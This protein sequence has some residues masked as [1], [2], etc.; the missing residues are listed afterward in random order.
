[1]MLL[2]S[3]LVSKVSKSVAGILEQVQTLV[4]ELGLFTEIK[5][6]NLTGNRLQQCGDAAGDRVVISAKQP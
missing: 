4:V 2:E 1:M 3:L 6:M 5:S